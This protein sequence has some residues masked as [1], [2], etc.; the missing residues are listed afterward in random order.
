MPPWSPRRHDDSQRSTRADVVDLCTML[1]QMG[2]QI[3]GAG[4]PTMTI[5]GVERLY[6]PNIG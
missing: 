1:N 2:A 4:T 3:S 5:I 6:P